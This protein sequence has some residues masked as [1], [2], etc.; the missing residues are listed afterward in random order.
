MD[1]TEAFTYADDFQAE[2]AVIGDASV[3]AKYEAM[4]SQL[5]EYQAARTALLGELAVQ[6]SALTTEWTADKLDQQILPFGQTS[7]EETIP[8]RTINGVAHTPEEEQAISWASELWTNYRQPIHQL[9]ASKRRAA[10]QRLDR[11]LAR[12]IS[13]QTPSGAHMAH[14]GAL[15]NS[16]YYGCWVAEWA[17][18]PDERT[19][20]FMKT[21]TETLGSEVRN[22]WQQ[23]PH[24]TLRDWVSSDV[25][26]SPLLPP[27]LPALNVGHLLLKEYFKGPGTS[28]EIIEAGSTFIEASLDFIPNSQIN[29]LKYAAKIINFET[30]IIPWGSRFCE[31]TFAF[32]RA[33]IGAPEA[34]AQATNFCEAALK[35]YIF[36]YGA[37]PPAI[38]SSAMKDMLQQPSFAKLQQQIYQEFSRGTASPKEL[39]RL[40]QH[41]SRADPGSTS[42]LQ[43]FSEQYHPDGHIVIPGDDDPK[44]KALNDALYRGYDMLGRKLDAYIG[45]HFGTN[46]S[47]TEFPG[48]KIRGVASVPLPDGLM[49]DVLLPEGIKTNDKEDLMYATLEA[50]QNLLAGESD[51]MQAFRQVRAANLCHIR[52]VL[53]LPIQTNFLPEATLIQLRERVKADDV[54]I[55]ELTE[56]AAIGMPEPLLP[57]GVTAIDMI[58]TLTTTIRTNPNRFVGRRGIRFPLSDPVLT[59]RGLQQIDMKRLEDNRLR[60]SLKR[61]AAKPIVFHA[62]ASTL[63]LLSDGRAVHMAYETTKLWYLSLSMLS[64]WMTRPAVETSEGM[65]EEGRENPVG[66][67]HFGYL[68]I[69]ENGKKYQRGNAQWYVFLDEQNGD[70]DEASARR[71]LKDPTGKGRNSTYYGER[72]DAIEREPLEIYIAPPP[73]ISHHQD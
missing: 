11:Q 30:D 34:Y 21:I 61:H 62:D 47:P 12:A 25:A 26:V 50:T 42:F 68:R 41:V 16:A 28:A 67:G 58:Q 48:V 70:L 19:E 4:S 14:D 40:Q 64:E 45:Y 44:F 51:E 15:L 54:M 60:I 2:L 38:I 73:F 1:R 10:E 56:L 20:R 22:N 59:S 31:T 43:S 32:P 52:P 17:K 57:E 33:S 66:V 72:S 29:S 37:V 18:R 24:A 65:V 5:P 3:R 7:P 49:F 35:T 63:E 71:A 9:K 39:D 69:E 27:E 8:E 53:R 55:H 23:I 6:V 46:L 36:C 13:E